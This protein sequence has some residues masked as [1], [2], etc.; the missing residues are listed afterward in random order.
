MPRIFRDWRRLSPSYVPDKP[1]HRMEI[2]ERVVSRLENY[3]L[4]RIILVGGKGSGKTL[5][6]KHV[7]KRIGRGIKP[8]YVNV[9]SGGGPASI[10]DKLGEVFPGF[11]YRGK[12]INRVFKDFLRYIYENG[13]KVLLILDDSDMLFT[14]YP[15]FIH[16]ISRPE[17]VFEAGDVDIYELFRLLYTAS[18]TNIFN[19]LDE[20]TRSSLRG[21][22]MRLERYGYDEVLDILTY[23]CEEAF[24]EGVLYDET[25][26]TAADISYKYS[27]N[28]RYALD[29]LSKAGMLAEEAGL[30]HVTPEHI[31]MARF[32]LPPSISEEMIVTLD[33]HG[34]MILYS[35]A[36]LLL[37]EDTAYISNKK[38]RETYIVNIEGEE[39][40]LSEKKYME[41][42]DKMSSDGLISKRM[43]GEGVKGRKLL[44][45][46]PSMPAMLIVNRIDM[47]MKL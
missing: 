43:S 38:L 47:F 16:M 24:E 39:K 10:V 11:K 34:R 4:S 20:G 31:R 14:R 13:M 45:G 3:P 2:L 21:L 6:A 22:I 9:E 26:E 18:S 17:E 35:L 46:L 32:D 41:L 23:R 29:L 25:I 1:L 33:I 19:Q 42:I 36:R 15:E 8:I 7:E 37:K 30:K 12:S 27:S 40:P 44:I 28:I 5:I